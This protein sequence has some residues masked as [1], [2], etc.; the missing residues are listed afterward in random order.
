[1]EK[2]IYNKMKKITFPL[3]ILI[4]LSLLITINYQTLKHSQFARTYDENLR[5]GSGLQFYELL[6]QNP[7][8]PINKKLNSLFV[9]DKKQAHPH[10]FE[11]LL[12]VS[13]KIQE[14]MGIN[15]DPGILVNSL[16]LIILFFSIYKIGSIVYDRKTGFL[17]ALFTSLLPFVFAH[18]RVIMLDFPLMCMV[19]L[20]YLYLLKTNYFN[21]IYY[22]I[23]FGCLF[24]LSQMIKATA[25]FFILPSSLYYFIK[26]YSVGD[27]KKVILNFTI[28]MLAFFLIV[29]SIYL[30]PSN[31]FAFE[32]YFYKIKLPSGHQ[33]LYYLKNFIDYTGPFL[34]ILSCPLLFSYLINFRKREKIFFFW[35]FIPLILFSIS[36]S[37]FMRYLLPVIPAFSLII[38]QEIF[39]NNLLRRFGR[40][41]SFLLVA[42]SVLQYTL[43]NYGILDYVNCKNLP[44]A[45]R[46]LLHAE[47]DGS[48]PI[49]E[50]ILDIF[51]KEALFNKDIRQIVFLS[52]LREIRSTLEFQ[53]K[54]YRLPFQV[55]CPLVGDAVYLR[56][57]RMDCCQAIRSAEYIIEKAG[58]LIET[59]RHNYRIA[60][61][62]ERCFLKYKDQFDVMAEIK[63]FSGSDLYIY[64]KISTDVK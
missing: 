3:L 22:S 59:N 64:K 23:L 47:R 40:I 9:L 28:S 2:A 53:F 30:R 49:A 4:T 63:D 17:A 14:I 60:Q 52:N 48:I 39:S 46:G 42:V 33:F 29:A 11:F 61:E 32:F 35:F 21:S 54:K 10:L 18:S 19:S 15:A 38:T 1:L 50:K 24:G 7:G 44:I 41:Y 5:L 27:K 25:I 57:N 43:F 20:G 16:F 26:S 56:Y 58:D 31:W 45:I 62:V 13:W 37:R 34:L 55:I 6:F 12:A 36:S 51:K 8:M